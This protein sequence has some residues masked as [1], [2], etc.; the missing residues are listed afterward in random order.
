MRSFCGYLRTTGGSSDR[1]DVEKEMRDSCN[2]ELV[3]AL[4]DGAV[5]VSRAGWARCEAHLKALAGPLDHGIRHRYEC[6]DLFAPRL[7][8]GAA[9]ASELGC[10]RD[11]YCDDLE[12]HSCVA[13]V[14]RGAVCV[15][16]LTGNPCVEGSYCSSS[17]SGTPTRKTCVAL[18][19]D[20]EPC[21]GYCQGPAYCIGR[22]CRVRRGARGEGCQPGVDGC[23]TGLVCDLPT[24][25]CVPRRP[26]GARCDDSSECASGACS[27][28]L[29]TGTSTCR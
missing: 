14:P 25:V 5:H 21:L 22:T 15:Q 23:D 13:R 3:R 6:R 9:C 26:E 29:R 8:V 16:T 17:A 2:R 10:R 18:P 28:S 1:A 20:G 24:L 7:G 12:T 19:K 4:L 11:L 27:T